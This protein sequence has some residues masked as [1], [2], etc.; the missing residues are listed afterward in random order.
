MRSGGS[1]W[2][3]L[4]LVRLFLEGHAELREQRE[5][6]LISRGVSDK[7]DVHALHELDL[8]E[9]DLR[10]DALLGKAHGVIA[11]AI[12]LLGQAPEVADTRDCESDQTIEE[13]PHAIATQRD[14]NP[15]GATHAQAEA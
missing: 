5:A 9:L 2:L 6:F 1:C 14:G 7:R 15:N 3:P 11:A 4:V 8:V 12:Q 13:L 10:E